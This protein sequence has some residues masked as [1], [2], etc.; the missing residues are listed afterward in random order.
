MYCTTYP[1]PGDISVSTTKNM[2]VESQE[3]LLYTN[4]SAHLRTWLIRYGSRLHRFWRMAT[5]YEDPRA[6]FETHRIKY[7]LAKSSN[8]TLPQCVC[9]GIFCAAMGSRRGFKG[10]D[11]EKE[12]DG[13]C[14]EEWVKSNGAPL[15]ID[16]VGLLLLLLLM[17][18][19]RLA[20]RKNKDGGDGKEN[21]S[22]C[23]S[24]LEGIRASSIYSRW[25]Y[26]LNTFISDS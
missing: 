24:N 26:S 23:N 19:E 15:C 6:F 16:G 22:R 13:F 2:V 8:S 10:W 20:R 25:S 21:A 14:E 5:N 4:I 9:T 7:L 3:L 12:I 11:K 18:D 1:R 17:V